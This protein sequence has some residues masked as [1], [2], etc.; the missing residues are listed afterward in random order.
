MAPSRFT[1]DKLDD[2]IRKLLAIQD[3][4]L[5]LESLHGEDV[6]LAGDE[7]RTSARNLLHY[8]GLRQHDIREL[9]VELTRFGLSSLGRAESYTLAN[10][11]A[12]LAVLHRLA[13]R[14]YTRPESFELPVDFTSGPALLER[15]TSLLLGDG[16]PERPTRIMVTLPT[17]AAADPEFVLGLV[18]A[19]MDIARIN[20][21]HDSPAQWQKMVQNIRQASEKAGHP[22]R[23]MMDLAGPKLRTAGIEGGHLLLSRGDH[24]AVLPP[25][26]NGLQVPGRLSEKCVRCSLPEIIRDV[27]VGHRIW[28]DDGKLGGVVISEEGGFL[29]VEITQARPGGGKLRNEKGI[30]LPDTDLRMPSLTSNDLFHLDFAARFVDMVGLSFVRSGEDVLLLEDCLTERG[31]DHIGIV[32]KIEN[33]KAFENLPRLLLVGL[34]SPPLGVM[35][36]RGDLAVEVGFERLAE[37]QEEILWLAEAAHVPVIWATQV[38]E[39]LAKKG[40]PS[41]A[42]VTDA[43]MSVRAECVML[44]KG[45][46]VTDAVLFLDNILRRM[47]SHQQKKRATLRRLS[48][49]DLG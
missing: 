25:D 20:S 38:L 1:S 17:H 2:L 16:N 4:M 6:K 18:Q 37:A 15:H 45:P 30:N 19:G 31:G 27:R 28:F 49:S 7:Y 47:Q 26:S 21:A 24:L 44:N 5:Q 43:A 11:D 42:E 29:E 40:L 22:V 41:R 23:I 48:V 32:L 3:R 46:Y 39:S 12:V 33:A 14:A 34:R 36:A 8:L 13:N 10:V 9:Q 35:V